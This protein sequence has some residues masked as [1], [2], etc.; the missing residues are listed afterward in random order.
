MLEHIENGTAQVIVKLV[1]I[2]RYY[3]AVIRGLRFTGVV[4]EAH[5]NAF[6][7]PRVAKDNGIVF[8]KLQTPILHGSP[9]S[10]LVATHAF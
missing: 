9:Q 7:V 10:T 1:P 4:R 2:D 8:T 6:Y 5:L 3:A